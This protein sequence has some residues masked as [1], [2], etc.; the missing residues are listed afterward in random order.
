MKTVSTKKNTSKTQ[1]PSSNHSAKEAPYTHYAT[2][3]SLYSG[4]TRAYLR[5][6]DI[7][8]IE[9]I[10][11]RKVCK[12]ILIPQTGKRMVPVLMSPDGLCVQDT[13]KIIDFLETRYPEPSVY[14]STPWQRLVALLLEVYGDE[15]LLMPAMHYRWHYKKDNLWF[16]LQEFGNWVEPE[17]PEELK[18]IA[19]IRLALYFGELYKPVLGISR[20]IHKPL[21]AWYEEFLRCFNEHLDIH[22]FLLGTRPCLGDFGFM[23]PLYAH[24]YRD[25]YP[26]KLM[27]RIAPNVCRW[28]ERMNAPIPGSGTFL[29]KD[30]VPETL[31][32][33]LK[34][35]FSEQ[36]PVLLDTVNKVDKWLKN[37]PKEMTVPRFIGLHDYAIGNVKA[38]R[39][40]MP[41][42]QWMFQRPVMFYQGL[43][44]EEKAPLNKFLKQLGGYEGL[45]VNIQTRLQYENHK[46]TRL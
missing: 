35:M 34:M 44:A 31:Y 40:I 13:T 12:E 7:P 36:F 2:E 16:I 18:R 30:E 33:I 42:S 38:K 3:V 46:L 43:S 45:N 11:S 5:Y 39:T 4:K 26:G 19:G 24:L 23:A 27:R 41:Y 6:K 17:W 15:W 37:Y 28:V 9:V 22:P 8:F 1:T 20:K 29:P 10:P 32:P 14:P 25:P 21:E